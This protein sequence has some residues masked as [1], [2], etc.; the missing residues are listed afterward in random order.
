MAKKLYVGNL[1]FDTT[2]AELE[3]AFAQFGEV[4]SAVVIKDSATGRSRGFGFVE[5]AEEADAQKAK[6]EMNGQELGGRNLKVDEARDSR[7][8]GG[9]RRSGGG[10][11]YGSNRRQRY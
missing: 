11:G 4:V 2:E 3:E 10:G 6:E 7:G 9:G 5:F 1:N 8:G